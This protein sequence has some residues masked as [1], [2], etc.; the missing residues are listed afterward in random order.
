M[1]SSARTKHV[2]LIIVQL[3][4]SKFLLVRKCSVSGLFLDPCNYIQP[5]GDGM[6]RGVSLW[7][8][9]KENKNTYINSHG[10]VTNVP[11][12]R[13]NLSSGVIN[14]LLVLCSQKI[15]NS[16]RVKDTTNV[17]AHLLKSYSS[18]IMKSIGQQKKH[19]SD[20]LEPNNVGKN[21]FSRNTN[22][23]HCRGIQIL[24]VIGGVR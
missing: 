24:S 20:I 12:H 3:L 2:T 6:A 10:A 23:G 18:L 16:S 21:K 19:Q 15:W 5:E 13:P 14:Q 7:L 4:Q 17:N 1:Y 9:R 11:C 22:N 8:D